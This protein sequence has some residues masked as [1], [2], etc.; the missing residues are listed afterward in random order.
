MR[1]RQKT[2]RNEQR[3]SIRNLQPF[4]RVCILDTSPTGLSPQSREGNPSWALLPN[5]ASIPHRLT[6]V[7]RYWKQIGF[8]AAD[9][10]HLAGYACLDLLRPDC[11]F[12]CSICYN[13]LRFCSVK[14]RNQPVRAEI[15]AP[16]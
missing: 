2:S 13:L 6:E 5:F 1:A 4:S 8:A 10:N 7:T 16:L 3:S 9:V 14:R 11:W 12:R 15:V